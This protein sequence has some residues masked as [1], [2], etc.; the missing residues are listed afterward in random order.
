MQDILFYDCRRC[1]AF[2][3]FPIERLRNSR[4][5]STPTSTVDAREEV[6]KQARSR[7]PPP[8]EAEN[9]SLL[10]T[11]RSTVADALFNGRPAHLIGPPI[12]VY[13]TV[14][15]SFREVWERVEQVA[16]FTPEELQNAVEICETSTAYYHDELARLVDV[17]ELWDEAVHPTFLRPWLI[18]YSKEH[19][20]KPVGAA[21]D[22][23]IS[24]LGFPINGI[25]ELK[26][27]VG[28]GGSDAFDQAACD[29][30]AHL[31]SEAGSRLSQFCCLPSFLVGIQGSYICVGGA[32]FTERIVV[33]R[34]TDYVFLG[35]HLYSCNNSSLDKGILRVAKLLKAIK[36]GLNSVSEFWSQIPK[37]PPS[38]SLAQLL[39][40]CRPHLQSVMINETRHSISYIRKIDPSKT[41]FEAKLSTPE[42]EPVAMIVKFTAKYSAQA[43]RCLSE[44]SPPLAPAL[45]Y[46]QRHPEYDCFVII[47]AVAP[48]SSPSSGP[49]QEQTLR[50]LRVGLETL[51]T[52]N[53]VFGDLRRPNILVDNGLVSLIDFDWSGQAGKAHYPVTINLSGEEW[54]EGVVRGGEIKKEHDLEMLQKLMV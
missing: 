48:G 49:L 39:L 45:Y 28:E 6:L 54:A 23:H 51:H 8:A 38:K 53:L 7:Q 42:A 27:G 17:Q 36:T 1:V 22:E 4:R 15:Q 24:G 41:V 50:H 37:S 30:R 52:Q 3:T 18:V 12:A 46:C 13:T 44:L 47:M 19:Y 43:H 32:I 9:S 16:D 35:T 14:F 10:A 34:F 40:P 5:V 11:Q 21:L 31:T 26:N 20:A 33:E 29:Y 25:Q 2:C